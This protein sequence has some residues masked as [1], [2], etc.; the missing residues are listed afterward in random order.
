MI[1]FKYLRMFVTLLLISVTLNINAM[2]QNSKEEEF[3]SCLTQGN[4]KK[5]YDLLEN[6][7]RHFL[8]ALS[9]KSDRL[10][11]IINTTSQPQVASDNIDPLKK[12][13]ILGY[14]A[15]E[16][17][18]AIIEF[19]LENGA[20]INAKDGYG[21]TPLEHAVGCKQNGVVKLLLK[22][23]KLSAESKERA[24]QLAK[25]QGETLPFLR[26]LDLLSGDPSYT[27]A[28]AARA[29]IEKQTIFRPLIMINCGEVS[30]SIEADIPVVLLSI[31]LAQKAAPII[32]TAPILRAFLM[33]R[34]MGL[35]K[36]GS[37]AEAINYCNEH[38]YQDQIAVILSRVPFDDNEW[39]MYMPKGANFYLLIPKNFNRDGFN[40]KQL[41]NIKINN[42][43]SESIREIVEFE[44][45][46]WELESIFTQGSSGWIIY[47]DGHGFKGSNIAGMPIAQ[48]QDLL[49]FFS[50]ALGVRFLFYQT[51]YGAGENLVNAYESAAGQVQLP[52]VLASGATSDATILLGVPFFYA[53]QVDA[54][55]P[56]VMNA[57]NNFF[58]HI[59]TDV[60]FHWF[61]LLAEAFLNNTLEPSKSFQGFEEKRK[62]MFKV[63]R[64]E[65]KTGLDPWGCVLFPVLHKD[66][67]CDVKS[68]HSPLVFPVNVGYP[69][70]VRRPDYPESTVTI[71]TNSVAQANTEIIVDKQ[72]AFL[73][74]PSVFHGDINISGSTMP[75]VVSMVPGKAVHVIDKISAPMLSLEDLLIGFINP[76][77]LSDKLFF[78]KDL[79]CKNYKSSGIGKEEDKEKDKEQALKLNNV[80]IERSQCIERSESESS[81]KIDHSIGVRIVLYCYPHYYQT[82]IKLKTG[83]KNIEIEFKLCANVDQAQEDI[84]EMF[85][86]YGKK[87]AEFEDMLKVA[88]PANLFVL[89]MKK[90]LLKRICKRKLLELNREEAG[91]RARKQPQKLPNKRM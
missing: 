34:H 46:L 54:E 82:T 72:D 61:F 47:M 6:G 80:C 52:F 13:P 43:Q 49:F 20:D 56:Y 22:N 69:I 42:L 55:H 32:I 29:K 74:Y 66:V 10:K 86:E 53:G 16:G 41:K 85:A 67:K 27:K 76:W 51:C 71:V 89:K 17:K 64:L 70:P 35:Q 18:L 60:N 59:L 73:L 2:Q 90:V 14:A 57:Q 65:E 44:K 24:L 11:K 50:Q 36:A 91:R 63:Y 84:K 40:I 38:G 31:A 37:E 77:L 45:K 83:E 3:I 87:G 23:V 48:Y 4:I 68:R 30:P 9:K 33:L 62:K 81:N 5:A 21:C 58:K 7:G 79:T 12:I 1:F 19:L 26:V 8:Y 78:I 25:K 88:D 28:S 75:L 15:T 39:D